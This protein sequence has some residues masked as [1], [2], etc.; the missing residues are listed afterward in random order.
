VLR[1]YSGKVAVV[2][3]AAS[4]LGRAFAH[5]LASRHCNLALIDV[6]SQ[7]LATVGKALENS[8]A[9]VT[10][11]C[12]DVASY[13]AMESVAS[14]VVR[15]HQGVHFLI[16]NAGVSVSSQFLS[17]DRVAFERVLAVNYL[18]MVYGC[19]LFLP[20]LQRQAEAQILNVS[21]CF[22]WVGYPG[23]TAYAA[24]KAA[25]R[26]FSECLRLE[27]ADTTVGVTVL[28][29]GVV[30]TNLV[31]SGACDSPEKHHREGAFLQS[32]GAA[33][34]RVVKRCLDAVK[35]NPHQIVIGRDYHLLDA[36]ARLSPALAAKL[37]HAAARRQAF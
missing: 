14:A 5:E 12:V 6:D 11:H 32:R 3:G 22:A 10:Q 26:A 16:N 31:R 33:P 1:D 29:P 25:V 24:S 18:G 37:I 13:S 35:R 9:V 27:L 21:S 7:R 30:R 19:R 28:Y 15:H 20:L 2:T 36:L 23:K 17:T 8:A 34:E 4:G